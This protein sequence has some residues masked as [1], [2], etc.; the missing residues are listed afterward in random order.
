MLYE[1]GTEYGEIMLGTSDTAIKQLIRTNTG[2]DDKQVIFLVFVF[3]I[4]TTSSIKLF[5]NSI[6]HLLT[7][8]SVYSLQQMP[9]NTCLSVRNKQGNNHGRQLLFGFGLLSVA[10]VGF[11]SSCRET[12]EHG[13]IPRTLRKGEKHAGLGAFF[14][15]SLSLA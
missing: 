9:T 14:M 5:L 3:T 1:G 4:Y 10:V 2:A 7:Q 11:V 6:W 13:K 12:T 8:P 15:L